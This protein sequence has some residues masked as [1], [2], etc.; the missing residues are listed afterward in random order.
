MANPR[1]KRET[2]DSYHRP[3]PG[4]SYIVQSWW[5]L[6]SAAPDSA[7]AISFRASRAREGSIYPLD[8]QKSAAHRAIGPV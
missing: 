5:R 4:H 8:A 2:R 7:S 6:T 3:R 1:S